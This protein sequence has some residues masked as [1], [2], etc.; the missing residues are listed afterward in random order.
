MPR[1]LTLNEFDMDKS[2]AGEAL[3]LMLML[4]K[5]I[6]EKSGVQVGLADAADT[7]LTLSPR[8]AELMLFILGT[9]AAKSNVS[10][11]V[12]DKNQ[13]LTVE[14]MER[15][16]GQNTLTRESISQAMDQVGS[17]M[18][19]RVAASAL[20]ELM[21]REGTAVPRYRPPRG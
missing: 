21:K 11:V 19:Y 20:I 8:L 4:E 7:T 17:Q 5:G 6:V 9:L 3:R 1:T 13:T 15:L 2:M 16:L 18:Q 10:V 12:I 14:K